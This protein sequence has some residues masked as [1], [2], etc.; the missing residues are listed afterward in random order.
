MFQKKSQL[1]NRFSFRTKWVQEGVPSLR[2]SSSSVRVKDC[3]CHNHVTVILYSLLSLIVINLSLESCFIFVCF[4]HSVSNPTVSSHTKGLNTTIWW[5]IPNC[6]SN[7]LTYSRAPWEPERGHRQ[8]EPAQRLLV[9]ALKHWSIAICCQGLSPAWSTET[10]S[11]TKWPSCV[12]LA[13]GPCEDPSH[14]VWDAS[15]CVC[16]LKERRTP[17][18]GLVALQWPGEPFVPTHGA[19]PLVLLHAGG[20]APGIPVLLGWSAVFLPLHTVRAS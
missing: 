2:P 16:L 3:Y 18:Q 1:I 13:L 6:R 12:C 15:S 8:D 17:K 14:T 11:P 19:K 5:Q 4:P 7:W 9:L 20:F 10:H